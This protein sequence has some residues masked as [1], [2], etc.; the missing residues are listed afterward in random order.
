MRKGERQWI[1]AH[2]GTTALLTPDVSS[3]GDAAQASHHQVDKPAS[4]KES[5]PQSR[6]E[7]NS[8]SIECPASTGKRARDVKASHDRKKL[9]SVRQAKEHKQLSRQDQEKS[10]V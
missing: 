7:T 4:D 10:G 2:C 5:A 3:V 9:K 8:R 1:A 6:G